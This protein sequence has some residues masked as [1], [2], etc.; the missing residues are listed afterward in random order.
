M[1]TTATTEAVSSP[2]E[3]NEHWNTKWWGTTSCA[4]KKPRAD[5]KNDLQIQGAGR[6]SQKPPT[7]VVGIKPNGKSQI[8][9]PVRLEFNPC[10][11][12]GC[13]S[14][15][16]ATVVGVALL[17][18]YT[19]QAQNLFVSVNSPG[20]GAIYELT[21][22]GEESTFT[23]NVDQPRGLAFDKAGDL[24]A[25]TYYGDIYEF[26][27][28]E[29]QSIF[30]AVGGILVGSAFD[31]AGNL[32][33]SDYR[34]GFIYEIAPDGTQSTFASGLKGPEA[35]AFNGAGNLFVANQQNGTITEI[36]PDGTQSNF[37]SGLSFP[38]GLA[39]DSN[40]DL[41]VSNQTGDKITKITPDG[42]QTTF[43]SGLDDPN[44]I[45][46]DSAGDLFVANTAGYDIVKITPD[47]VE[48]I[49]ASGFGVGEPA[50]VAFQPVPE[51]QAQVVNGTF[52]VTVSMPSPY[53]STILQASTNLVNWVGVY[54]NT[55]AFT[56]TDL[57][58]TASGQCFYRAVLGP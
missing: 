25:G 18:G 46:F 58:V 41:F 2:P 13:R 29:T 12:S 17:I 31:S 32:F 37:V 34:G 24:F 8:I 14:S 48:S 39:F 4:E 28:D 23:T 35:L 19:I 20:N 42:T 56:Y 11:R 16:G 9:S 43:I 27:S 10:I 1:K 44:G 30:G 36:T 33:I 54:T 50:E 53:Y 57:T 3:E 38:A 45:A 5:W 47:G 49:F 40:G 51:L 22:N 52:Q 26:A 6:K 7:P 21:P 15:I 55:P